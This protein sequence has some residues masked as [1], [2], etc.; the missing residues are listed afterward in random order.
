LFLKSMRKPLWPC[1]L[2]FSCIQ[3]KHLMDKC[4]VELP[5]GAE[6][7]LLWVTAMMD[8]V[9]HRRS[10]SLDNS[11]WAGLP[12]VLISKQDISNEL[13]PLYQNGRRGEQRRMMKGVN[14]SIIYLIYCKSICKCHNVPPIQRNSKK[15]RKK[16]FIPSYCSNSK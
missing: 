1:N 12:A 9:C 4:Q 7:R 2:H 6:N 15:E 14:S 16:N 13:K 10:S 5:P 11:V 8:S 3:N